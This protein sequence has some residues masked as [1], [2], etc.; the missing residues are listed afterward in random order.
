MRP[1]SFSLACLLLPTLALAAS[2]PPGWRFPDSSD[3]TGEWKD[4]DLPFHVRGDFN[5]D[6]IADDAWILFRTESKSWAAFAFVQSSDGTARPVQLTEARDG[7]AQ[8]YVLE[9]IRPSKTAYP[10]A[11]GKGYF[12][13]A[14]GEPLTITFRLPSI[15]L[16]LRES[17]CSA[18]VWQS[19]SGRFQ[20]V[21]MSD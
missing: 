5:G 3:R 18:F 7:S 1:L 19:K 6:G 14:K 10:T 2:P 17:S 12:E 20:Q 21:R 15:S 16:C 8:R 4:A 11:C 9:T 13:C